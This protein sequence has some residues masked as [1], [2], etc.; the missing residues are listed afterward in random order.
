M[1][2]DMVLI[3]MAVLLPLVPAVILYRFLPPGEMS[4]SGPFKGLEVK[5]TG[6]S[7]AYFVVFGAL[8]YALS[9]RVMS[10]YEL[11]TLEG[12]I[13][14]RPG[15]DL[16]LSTSPPRP[17]I[18]FSSNQL[19]FKISQVPLPI[20]ETGVIPNLVVHKG[21]KNGEPLPPE[22]VPLG[23]APF[24][25]KYTTSKDKSAHKLSINEP[26]K[27]G[28]PHIDTPYAPSPLAMPAKPGG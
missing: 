26:I 20:R 21:D 2:K 1:D 9:G 25:A 22:T 5:V 24:G 6:A 8:A 7:A 16:V 18:V 27:F 19:H 11:W 28:P 15:D 17:D 12:Y 4:V 14:A 10:D 13:D 3:L 23:D